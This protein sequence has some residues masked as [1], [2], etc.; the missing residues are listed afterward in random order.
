MCSCLDVESLLTPV[1]QFSR[2]HPVCVCSPGRRPGPGVAQSMAWNINGQYND[3]LRHRLMKV[4][5]PQADVLAVTLADRDLP[6]AVFSEPNVRA[7]L[8]VGDP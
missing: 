8:R 2:P 5:V 3:D 6:K 4:T 1:F 7:D